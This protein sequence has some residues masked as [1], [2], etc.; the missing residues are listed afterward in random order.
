[1]SAHG[2]DTGHNDEFAEG[3]VDHYLVQLWPA[4]PE[5]D[6]IVRVGSSS[7]RYWHAECGSRR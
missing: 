1:M 5:R 6:E 7:A 4:P 2:R 3:V